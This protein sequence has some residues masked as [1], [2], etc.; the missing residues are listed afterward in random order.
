MYTWI[1]LRL[2]SL[3]ENKG[4]DNRE[5]AGTGEAAR[6]VR[7]PR[8]SRSRAARIHRAV[9]PS[10]MRTAEHPPKKVIRLSCEIN[11]RWFDALR[12]SLVTSEGFAR[13]V[14]SRVCAFVCIL[15]TCCIQ[16]LRYARSTNLRDTGDRPWVHLSLSNKVLYVFFEI[17]PFLTCARVLFFYSPSF[18]H[19]VSKSNSW[20]VENFLIFEYKQGHGCGVVKLLRGIGDWV[21]FWSHKKQKIIANLGSC[22]FGYLKGVFFFCPDGSTQSVR[23]WSHVVHLMPFSPVLELPLLVRVWASL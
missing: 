13:Q 2:F 15:W 10:T 8:P 9:S 11:A 19:Y 22:Y 21:M 12:A 23:C 4:A 17:S 16:R 6:P 5:E 14:V 1:I 7:L 20:S 3:S 18:I